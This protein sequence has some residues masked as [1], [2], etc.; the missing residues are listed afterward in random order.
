MKSPGL[1]LAN[2]LERLRRLSSADRGLLLRIALLVPLIEIWLRL[3]GFKRVLTPLRKFAV[4][5]QATASPAAEV[6]RHSRL[7]FL[8]HRQLPFTGNCLARSLA[9]WYL[10]QRRGVPTEVRFGVR[11]H[12]GKISAHA[13]VEYDGRSLEPAVQECYTPFTAPILAAAHRAS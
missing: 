10:L 11:K 12:E 1:I 7:M 3:A 13:W 2:K 8:F 9:L 5:R 4:A 6:A